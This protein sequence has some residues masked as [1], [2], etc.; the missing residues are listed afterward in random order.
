MK[1]IIHKSPSNRANSGL[2][3]VLIKSASKLKLAL[4]LLVAGG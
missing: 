2:N 1:Y 3:S 4:G